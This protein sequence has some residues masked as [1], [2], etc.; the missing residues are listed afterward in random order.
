MRAAPAV[1]KS[2]GGLTAKLMAAVDRRGVMV[3][4]LLVPGN[5]AESP[6]SPGLLAD[7]DVAGVDELIRR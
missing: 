4:F 6:Q 3:T 1:G 5:A 2:R 7:I